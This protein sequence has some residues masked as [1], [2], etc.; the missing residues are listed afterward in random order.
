MVFPRSRLLGAVLLTAI[1]VLPLASG[2]GYLKI[3]GIDGEARD[4]DHAD[5]IDVDSFSWSVE[6]PAS[7]A[8]DASRFRG[9]A[10]F[11]DLQISKPVD[12]STPK[13][14]EAISSG[15]VFPELEFDLTRGV[16]GG[17]HVYLQWE[18]K[19]VQV[20]SYSLQGSTSADDP[21]MESVALNFEEIKVTYTE[22]D[23]TGASKGNVEYTWK[24]EE[25]ES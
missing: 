6:R 14:M 2:A 17:P 16:G 22:H 21:P 1:F 7:D 4:R 20:T 25:G 13:L 10:G 18:L 23:E 12:K 11:G 15:R 19:N 3:G 5:W 8:T 9:A 24:V